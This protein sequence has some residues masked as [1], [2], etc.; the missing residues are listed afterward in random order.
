MSTLK[1]I[2]VVAEPAAP[3]GTGA[4]S[5]EKYTTAQGFTAVRDGQT[6]RGE[7]AIALTGKP[8]WR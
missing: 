2:E 6:P 8:R 3:F 7:D 5:G 4:R 1:G